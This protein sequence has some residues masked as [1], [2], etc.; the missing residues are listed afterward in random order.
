VKPC[1]KLM[2]RVAGDL[3]FVP[4]HLLSSALAHATEQDLRRIETAT[5]L[6]SGIDLASETWPCWYRL[7][8][9]CVAH[10]LT[11][12]CAAGSMICSST[13]YRSCDCYWCMKVQ[14]GGQ[15]ALLSGHSTLCRTRVVC[16]RIASQSVI[17]VR[18]RLYAHEQ[19][20]ASSRLSS[21]RK[22]A[23]PSN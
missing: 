8:L 20:L 19:H 9:K 17:P 11:I 15:F 14:M 12:G 18:T 23:V 3:G 7:Y 21:V 6:G 10:S 1:R 2:Y 4:L 16:T 22:L 5:L 13:R